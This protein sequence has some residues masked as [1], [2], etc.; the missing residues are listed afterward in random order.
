M[1]GDR[2]QGQSKRLLGLGVRFPSAKGMIGAVMGEKALKVVL[3]VEAEYL[4]E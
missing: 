4:A 2:K 3:V 1:A